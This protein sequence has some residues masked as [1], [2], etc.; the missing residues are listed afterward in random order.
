MLNIWFK[1]M[2]FQKFFNYIFKEIM[3]KVFFFPP[4]FNFFLKIGKD[5][6]IDDQY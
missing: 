6:N 1:L 4:I 3:D 2:T 5:I